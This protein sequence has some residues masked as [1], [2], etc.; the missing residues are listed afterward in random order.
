MTGWPPVVAVV[1]EVERLFS[2]A[3]MLPADAVLNLAVSF[4]YEE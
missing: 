1:A 2:P 3:A 4:A